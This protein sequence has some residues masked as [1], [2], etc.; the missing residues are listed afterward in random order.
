M[1]LGSPQIPLP[2]IRIAPNPIRFTVRSPAIVNVPAAF[3]FTAVVLI[4]MKDSLAVFKFPESPLLEKSVC[5]AA[6]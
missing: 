4:A 2:V 1:S 6:N 5:G 3:A